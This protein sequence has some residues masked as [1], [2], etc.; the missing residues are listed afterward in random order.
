MQI[1][2]LIYFVN[3]VHTFVATGEG[4]GLHHLAHCRVNHHA[5]FWQLRPDQISGFTRG[6][7]ST[8]DPYVCVACAH[9]ECNPHTQKEWN[10][11]QG[12]AIYEL[13]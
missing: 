11:R 6:I 1:M 7:R 12:A 9:P 4:H 13:N 3:N 2:Y 5:L 10:P 8:R